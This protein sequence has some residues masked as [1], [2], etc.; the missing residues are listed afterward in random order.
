MFFIVLVRACL[1]NWFAR[2]SRNPVKSTHLAQLYTLRL[3]F[4]TKRERTGDMFESPIKAM[5][6]VTRLNKEMFNVRFARTY[7]T[8]FFAILPSTDRYTWKSSIV[9]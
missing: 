9:E 8:N 5:Q 1:I 2:I 4:T 3:T 6:L 7:S